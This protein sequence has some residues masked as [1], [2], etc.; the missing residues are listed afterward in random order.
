MKNLIYLLGL[1]VLVLTSCERDL[2][3]K[4]AP[5]FDV[6][7][8]STSH[9]AGEP[10]VFNF[11]G[12]ADMIY[13]YSGQVYND[14]EF[15]EGRVLNLKDQGATLSFSSSVEFGTQ[16]NQLA[17]LASNNFDGNYGSLASVKA[18]TWKDITSRF[19]LSTNNKFLAST[20]QDVSDLVTPGKPLYIAFKYITKPQAVNGLAR[21][22]SIQGLTLKSK[23]LLDGK[24][25][26]L[27]DQTYAA[28]RI[29]DQDT[30]NAPSRSLVTTSRVTLYG[31]VYKDPKDPKYDPENPIYDPKNPIYDPESDVYN[32]AAVRPEF[33]PYDPN[34]SFNDPTTETWAVS[35]PLFTDKV[36]LGPDHSIAVQGIRSP[37]AT[38][39]NYTYN[40]PGTYKAYFVASNATKDQ[41]KD[42]VKEITI[43]VVE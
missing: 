30:A 22:W 1:S 6:T 26:E 18:A 21:A 25:L 33:V 19:K 16:T 41:R 2:V 4:D 32:A 27:T 28:F 8:A 3:V 29:V 20:E 31:N 23:E 17:I 5:R 15:R 24:N 12:E 43:T 39:F 11:N 35:A 7:T 38:D 10:V 14:Y 9:K 13:F 36:D 34:S 42:T 40:K 37:Q